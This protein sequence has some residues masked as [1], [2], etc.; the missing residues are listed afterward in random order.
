MADAGTFQLGRDSTM[1]LDS[2]SKAEVLQPPDSTE[3]RVHVIAGH[4]AFSGIHDSSAPLRV[5]SNN[6][7]VDVLG[8]SFDVYD[9]RGATTISVTQGPVAKWNTRR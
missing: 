6:V 1:T 2:R 8:T 4:V 3:T 5:V 7:A 9:E